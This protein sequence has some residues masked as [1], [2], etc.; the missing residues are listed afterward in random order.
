MRRPGQLR[1]AVERELSRGL[2][3]RRRRALIERLRG[4]EAERR[5]WDRAIAA[6][7]ALEDRSVSRFELEQVERWL[8]EDLAADGVI[9][10]APARRRRGSAWLGATLATIASAVALVWWIG[11]DEAGPTLA[12]DELVARG[13]G[14]L[15]R[16]LALEPLCGEPPRPARARGCALD[17]LLG[18]SIRL[19]D[20]TLAPEAAASLAAADL[21]LSLFGVSDDGEVRYYLP[22]PGDPSLPELGVESRWRPL[23]LSIRLEVNHAP[24]RVR[25]FALASEVAPSVHDIDRL[26]AALRGQPSAT[27]DDLP[28]H[29]RLDR[30]A[31]GG[32][33]GELDRCASAETEFLILADPGGTKP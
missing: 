20:E 19:G 2:S 10:K 18:F 8:F 16:P 28:W 17:E 22:T 31:L 5:G 4:N 27:V 29:R 33:C 13:A 6:V 14:Q 15:A 23:P 9:A 21:Q 1:R 30:A 26:A 11:R 12:G 32:L 3:P 25:V 24:G 7:R